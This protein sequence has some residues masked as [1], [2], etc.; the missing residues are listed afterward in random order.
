[1][2]GTFMKTGGLTKAGR[3]QKLVPGDFV[4]SRL[5]AWQGSFGLVPE[6]ATPIFASNEFPAFEVDTARVMP[7][8]L[9]AWFRQ[10][11]VWREVENQCTGSTPGSRNRFKEERLLSMSV[12]LPTKQSQY[13][14]VRALKKLK[15]IEKA[16]VRQRLLADAFPK[17][18]RNGV[19]ASLAESAR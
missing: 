15:A 4:Y 13:D 10:P 3:L 7:E 16:T 8:Y 6:S 9:A 12:G 19:F 14:T 5:F 11:A 2:R 17:S 18:V 1:G